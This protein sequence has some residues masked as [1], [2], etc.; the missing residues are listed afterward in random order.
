GGVGMGLLLAWIFVQIH[1]RL[2]MDAPSNI[3]FT[4]I[5]PYFMYWIAEQL[6]CS[7]VLAVVSGGL[8]MSTRR[9]WFFNSAS[10]IKG[11]SVWESFV[12]ILNGIV[13][14]IIGLE[15]PEIVEGLHAK[16]IPMRTAI[17]YGVLM[18]ILLILAR[19]VS[20]YFA[21]I[22]T[23]IFRPSVAPRSRSRLRT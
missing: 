12:F 11:F 20:S 8:F 22:A 1:K 10:R 15:L 14:L 7:G 18:T 5:E 21:L 16:G 13:F 4:L 19:I 9:L 2:P 23:F 17:G 3:T 6:H